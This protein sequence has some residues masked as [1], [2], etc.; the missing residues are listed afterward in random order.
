MCE[1]GRNFANKIWNAARFVMSTIG[2][3]AGPLEVAEVRVPGL[4][5]RY[6]LS[7][8]E[9]TVGRVNDALA[10]FHFNDAALEIYDF[11]WHHFCDRYLEA[12]KFSRPDDPP[13]KQAVTAG[14]LDL[15]LKE[16]LALLHPI[17]PFLTEEIWRRMGE[18]KLLMLS[19]WPRAEKKLIF[20]EAEARGDFKFELISAARNLRSDYRVPP[21]EPVTFIIKP[22]RP[23]DESFLRAE[24][25]SMAFLIRSCRVE[26]DLA[27]RPARTVPSTR[28]AGCGIYLPLEGLVDLAQEK[29]R[30][31]KQYDRA[32]LELQKT[33]KRL[34]NPDFLAKA[35]EE[36]RAKNA[37][38]AEALREE[39]AKLKKIISSL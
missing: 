13:E 20:P 25:E 34:K 29:A 28:V 16:I 21:K 18:E 19:P 35:P 27:Y 38:K 39:V 31:Q 17:M 1:L 9:R 32:H 22:A 8:L 11:F 3:G 6:I 12:A 5:E 23:E 4:D 24:A 7:R 33:K 26:I 36:V 37:K 15:V 14:V 10:R 2:E 30:F